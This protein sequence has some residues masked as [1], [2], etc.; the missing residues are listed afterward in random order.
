M[1]SNEGKK[2]QGSVLEQSLLQAMRAV[3]GQIARAMQR[4][5]SER[6]ALG[7]QK[8]QPFADRV[9]LITSFVLNALGGNEVEIDSVLVLAEA[10]AKALQIISED[11]RG[12]LGKV[13]ISYCRAMLEQIGESARRGLDALRDDGEHELM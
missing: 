2:Q 13:R 3:D 8:W 6:E 9:E 12:D 11:L 7:V 4:S 10:Y 1:A 5:P